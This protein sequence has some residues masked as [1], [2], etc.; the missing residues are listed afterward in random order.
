MRPLFER[1]LWTVA[2]FIF[3]LFW[4]LV[5]DKHYQLAALTPMTHGVNFVVALLDF[6]VAGLPLK[7]SQVWSPMAFGLLYILFSLIF[8]LAGEDSAIYAVLDWKTGPALAAGVSGG[9]V[10]VAFPLLFLAF[11][12]ISYCCGKCN[13]CTKHA[14]YASNGPNEKTPLAPDDLVYNKA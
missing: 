2:F 10:F 13:C 14:V 7:I 5:Y 8:G 12:G 4:L 11:A 9:V 3:L 6:L 1:L